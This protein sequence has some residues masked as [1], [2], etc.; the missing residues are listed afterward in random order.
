VRWITWFKTET[1]DTPRRKPPKPLTRVQIPAAAPNFWFE[2][3]FS[4]VRLFKARETSRKALKVR[5]RNDDIHHYK[6]RLERAI[7][8]VKNHPKITEENKCKY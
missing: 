6:K 8:Y 3:V 1:S 7:G 5:N 2:S 4:A